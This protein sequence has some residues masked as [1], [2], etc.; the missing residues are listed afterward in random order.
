MKDV[1]QFRESIVREYEQ[2]SR[3]FTTIA[4]DDIREFVDSEYARGRYWPEPLIQINPSYKK[5]CSVQELVAEGIVHPACGH[6]FKTGKPEGKTRDL[7][8]YKHQMDALAIA[9][10]NEPYVVTTGTGSG[11]SIAFF[12]PIVDRILRDREATGE[13]RTRAIIIYPMNALA[14]SQLEELGKFL[15]GY[16]ES[17]KPFT[18]ARYTGQESQE[19]RKEIADNPP[20]ILL[21]NFMMLELL[22]TRY[23]ETDR[24]VIDHCRGLQ[25]LVLDEL[26]TYRGR[27][28][29][30]V[31]FLVRRVRQ[32]LEAR[33]MLCIGTSATMS[34][35][36][37]LQDQQA[38]VAQVSSL[39]F[40]QM[41]PATNV[42]SETLA[43]VTDH[44]QSRQTMLQ[45]LPSRLRDQQYQWN[46]V[47]EFKRDP[48][49]VWVETTLGITMDG[50]SAPTRAVPLSMT[51]ASERLALDAECDQSTAYRAL[52]KFLIAAHSVEE[53]DGRKPFAFK[54]H[55]FISGPGKVLMTLGSPGERFITMT[56]QRFAP[57]RNDVFLYPAYFCRECGQEYH[58]VELEDNRWSPREIDALFPNDAEDRFGFLVPDGTGFDFDGS[59]ES[60]PD[61]WI[62]QHASGPRVKKEYSKY[63]PTKLTLDER[64]QGA[65][66]VDGA[67]NEYWYIPGHIRF[68]PRCGTVHE[69]MGKDINRL[70]SLSGEGRSS[71]TTM[72]TMSV[73][74]NLFDEEPGADGLDQRKMLGFTDNRQ[75]AALQSGHFNDFVFLVTL[76]GGIVGALQK[77]GGVLTEDSLPEEVFKAIGFNRNDY[78][79][80]SEYLNNP[81]LFGLNLSDAQRALKFVL[82]YRVIRDFRK[83]WRFN[84]PSLDQLGLVDIA[85]IG[86]DEYVQ[87][88]EY[89]MPAHDA[90]RALAP[91]KRKELFTLVFNE[92]RKNLCIDSRFLDPGEQERMK[93]KAWASLKERWSFAFDEKLTVTRYM[94]LTQLPDRLN[95]SRLDYISGGVRS[96][97]VRVIKRSL[98]WIGS[99]LEGQILHRKDSEV[100]EI[101]QSILEL[102]RD[103]GYV[104]EVPLDRG[105]SGWCLQSQ[106]LEW[107]LRAQPEVYKKVSNNEFFRQVYL[108]AAATLALPTHNLFEYES[109]EHTAQVDNADRMALEARF[110]F[111]Q[112]DKA[113]WKEQ[114]YQGQLERLPVLFCSPTMELG[115][116]I[117]S[118]NTVYMRNVPPTPANYAQRSG[119]AGRSGQPALVIT[120]CTALSPHDQWFFANAPEMVH[121]V[122]KA[123]TLDLSN[124]DLVD[125]HLDAIWLSCL[126]V[127]IESS[128]AVLLKLDEAGYPVLPVLMDEL[129]NPA[130]KE[131]AL[132]Q[133]KAIAIELRQSLSED[134]K[135]LTD[136][137]IEQIISRAPDGFDKAFERWRNLYS[138]TLRQMELADAIVRGH[139]TRPI[140][141]DSAT[142]RYTDAKRQLD[143]LL[144]SRATQNS[145]FY[146][147][148]YLAGQGFLPGYNFPRLPLMAWIPARG[149]RSGVDRDSGSMVSRPRFLGISEF[150][151]R[152][153][154]Y[155]DGRMYQVKKAKLSSGSMIGSGD[156]NRL[157]TIHALVCPSCGHG[158]FGTTDEPE[159]VLPR[160]ENCGAELPG[161]SR[162]ADL[163]KIDTVETEAV[164]RISVNDEER[165]RQG[166][167]IQ[168]MFRLNRDESGNAEMTRSLISL[169]GQAIGD[170][171]YSPAALL[172]R[173]NRGWKRRKNKNV[174]GFYIDPISGWWRAE[175][176]DENKG[177]GDADAARTKVP[178]QRIV[179]FVED[180]RN[181]LILTLAGTPS[182]EAM[183]TLQASLKRGIEQIYQI[184]E[185]ELAVEPLPLESDRKRILFYEAAEG[186]AGVLTRLARDRD[187]LATVARAALRILHYRIPEHLESVDDLMDEQG[188]GSRDPCVAACY[189]CLL[190]YYNQPEHTILD[191]RNPE[192]LGILVALSKGDVS[193]Q[194]DANAASDATE[195]T[196]RDYSAF[197]AFL[198]EKGCRRPDAFSYPFM[199]G[200]HAI[201]AVY[202][203]DK[204]AVFF[205]APPQEAQE[206]L[207]ERGY[208]VSVIGDTVEAWTSFLMN[209]T[210]AMPRTK[211]KQS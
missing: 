1:F 171:V 104:K 182:K 58:P 26:H 166:Y 59:I 19:D 86:M 5:A 33:E 43:Q 119:R 39:L 163:F 64:G 3:S 89:F 14:N 154:I 134:G 173:I 68:C 102:A 116:D 71:A 151:P 157:P 148:R 111:T 77:N 140:D 127:K 177:E 54:L 201:D 188:D 135:W 142:R 16:P 158:H 128:I 138:A 178:P 106:A 90:I 65:I 156:G 62:E 70:S 195:A 55:Q 115:V 56:A 2:F 208:T 21:T 103:Y 183:A 97:L 79:A 165:Q 203:S 161:S 37:S 78:E 6:I 32:R 36:G 120:Y 190:S 187:E 126:S 91:I 204:L 192:A 50:V 84:N 168:T 15:Y 57:G 45:L 131:R 74:K 47:D 28:G 207:R 174:L 60:L 17:Q 133:A 198:S 169:D 69:P 100:A 125:S 66:N 149:G 196:G 9:K 189:Q 191:R 61:F 105:Y 31:A 145:D 136:E 76:R 159:V 199:D 122:V 141:R 7:T 200:K 30:D 11:K 13:R 48:L 155:H 206:Y 87:A 20:D 143:V 41:V 121:G 96:R 98:L 22:L 147:Y 101:V 88:D 93:T 164:E 152:S 110:R 153:L 186:G 80:K 113:W 137:H 25:F 24:K 85:Y 29:A 8:L 108:G 23:D 52:Q 35:T 176:D 72:I 184:E 197:L 27:Q 51:Q 67:L 40:G 172:W 194:T 202:K 38:T 73:L 114:R 129:R 130:A 42:V 49:A 4:A 167:D 118:L 75:D 123:P 10:R 95:R 34:N 162:I 53:A 94:V 170:L 185:S 175:E 83:G 117:S 92:M 109:H 150:G 205:V 124:R 99:P 46:D 107:H 180:Y 63:V 160:C 210:G 132:E 112:K 209:N 179:P 18:A 44:T 211:E 139:A 193:I 181:I 12:L 144:S 82:G 81:E 146:T